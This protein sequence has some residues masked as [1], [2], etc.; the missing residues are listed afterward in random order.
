[1]FEWA[2]EIYGPEKF[3]A[4]FICGMGETEPEILEAAQKIRNMGGHN[5]MFAFFPEH[6]SLMEDWEPCRAN[7][8]AVQLARFLID[9]IGGHVSRMRFDA[10]GRLTDF[11]MDR[12]ALEALVDFGK[13]F[14]TSG[15]PGHDN[16]ISAC[17]RPYG[18]S[19][20]ADIHSFPFALGAPVTW[21]WCVGR[22]GETMAGPTRSHKSAAS[23][24]NSAYPR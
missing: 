11:G 24:P 6:G 8:A 15:C 17:N 23:L 9:Y 18:D 3:G 1:M 2:A 4:H 16:D 20:P 19:M 5:H 7:R 21:R 10:L 14:Q 13:P 22:G 12:N